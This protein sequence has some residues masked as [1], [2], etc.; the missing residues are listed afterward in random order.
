MARAGRTA[1]GGVLRRTL[2]VFLALAVLAVIVVG[3]S[4]L[5]PQQARTAT[6]TTS[7]GRT[8]TVCATGTPARASAR[9]SASPAP[10]GAGP[11]GAG[12]SGAGPSD[13][14]T[15]GDAVVAAPGDVAV[16]ASG[17][18]DASS[19]PGR[20]QVSR[21]G[22][23]QVDL[24]VDR[25]GHG[26]TLDR[27]A[28][29]VLLV[30]EGAMASTGSGAVLSVTADGPERGLEAAPCLPPTTAAWFPGVA[31]GAEDRTE[32]VLSNPDAAQAELDLKFYGRNGRV[33]VPGSPAVVVAAHSSRSVSL[34]DLVDA[35]SPLS[36]SVEATVGRV[37]AVARRIRSVADQ[38]AGADWIVPATPPTLTTDIPGVPGDAGA[39][40]L[41]VTNPGSVRATVA[42]RVLGLQGPY[43]PAG[44]DSLVVPPESS[45]SV[46]LADGLA[47][48]AAGI[49]LASDQ[50][51][52][53]AVTSTSARGGAGV[54]IAVQSARPTLVRTGVS[55]IASIDRA[56]AELVLSNGGAADIAVS[57]DVVSFAGVVLRSDEVVIA[58][59]GS[60]TRRL[61]APAPCYVV[62]RVPDGSSVVGGVVLS[63]LDGPVA[64]LSTIPLTSPDAAARSRRVEQDPA[65]GR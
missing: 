26:A 31:S 32:L 1:A 28:A 53:G 49:E 59:D 20:V 16:V 65:A 58:A 41:V 8:V 13:S 64:G 24:T 57:F 29:P 9:A 40:E 6:T 48:A 45:A 4:A 2:T 54:D 47:G 56:D 63:Q 19:P 14:P 36:V 43:A 30:G 25:S 12:P 22:S 18:A 15:P 21:L 42:I 50:P 61:N 44:A 52:T 62:V 5:A 33:V 60:A 39:R 17:P 55:A 27:A 46:A 10:S 34:T 7:T 37:S 35:Q 51:V 23:D 11:S 3:G 38:P